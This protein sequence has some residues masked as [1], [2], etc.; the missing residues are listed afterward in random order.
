MRKLTD[1]RQIRLMVL[2][3]AAVYFTSYISRNNFGALILEIVRAEGYPKPAVSL[4]VTVSFI[5]YGIGQLA[6]G[7][8][9]DRVSP[10]LLI[11]AGLLG[12]AI[13][14]L[15]I[16]FC[17][18]TEAM[19]AVW[20]VNGFL[21]ALLWPPLVKLMTAVFTAEV[22]PQ[23]SVRVSWG[24]SLGT[25]TVYLTAPLCILWSGWQSVF[26]LAAALCVGMAVLWLVGS[27]LVEKRL[28]CGGIPQEEARQV[29][30][31]L[32]DGHHLPAGII[33][34][35]LGIMAAI[36]CQG[37]IRDGVTT[38]MPT[39]IAETYQLGST[40]SILTGVILPLFSIICFQAALWLHD[41][42]NGNELLLSG[43]IF[44]IGT[45]CAVCLRL[46]VSYHAA[47]SVALFAVLTGCMHGVNLLLICMIPPHFAKYGGVSAISG[48]LNA[49]TYAGSALSAYGTAFFSE[50][51]GW[52]AV[53]ILW[54]MIALLGAAVC[55]AFARKWGLYRKN[56]TPD[57]I[58]PQ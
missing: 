3:C 30:A 28:G 55:F 12:S 5:T 13:M 14:N 29:Q 42:G 7:W 40:V 20:G 18:G 1:G 51:F 35:L 31:A 16:P 33:P 34:I 8:L 43:L 38:W 6:S 26:F 11:F 19:A 22:Y 57:F 24:S 15:L 58:K 37:A 53:I 39:F 10:R 48:V 17:P 2:L 46:T 25:I 32:P 54:T 52:N 21:Q 49:C 4:A 45:A 44:S 56:G 47:L 9:G 36:V 27:G 41:R 50:R 23:A